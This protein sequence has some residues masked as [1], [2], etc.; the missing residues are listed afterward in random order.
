VG[1]KFIL[2]FS[3][4]LLYFQTNSKFCFKKLCRI[5]SLPIFPPKF[6]FI[7]SIFYKFDHINFLFYNFSIH[8]F[9]I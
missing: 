1:P 7:F 2:K 3:I 6:I 9:C 8:I 5:F 4:Q